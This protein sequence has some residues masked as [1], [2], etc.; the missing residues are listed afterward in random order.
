M[1]LSDLKLTLLFD[2][3]PCDPRLSCLW[4]FACLLEGPGVRLLFDTGS[5]GRLLLRNMRELELEPTGLDFLFI[6]HAHWD[7]TGGLAAILGINPAVKIY[8]P[9]SFIVPSGPWEVVHI[10]EALEIGD[11]IFSTGELSGMEQ[12]L[13]VRAMKGLCIVVGCSHPGLKN[14]LNVSSQYGEN[15]MV[16]GGLHGF[17][18]FNILEDLEFICPTHCTRHIDRIKGIYPEKYLQGGA[19][20]VIE[21]D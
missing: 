18:D 10:K 9:K 5:N 3:E 19:G 13:V 8:A 21:F 6:S 7:H 14:I 15:W 11:D 20:R 17:S 4:G 12:A 16:V 1:R 2:N